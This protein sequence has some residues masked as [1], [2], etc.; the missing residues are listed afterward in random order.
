M[1]MTSAKTP[2]LHRVR[3]VPTFFERR[4]NVYNINN[5][6]ETFAGS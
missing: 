3:L 6:H 1:V 2:D 5:P 4:M